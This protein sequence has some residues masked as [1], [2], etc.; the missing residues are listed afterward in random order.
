LRLHWVLVL[1]ITNVVSNHPVFDLQGRH[2]GTPDLLD[3]DTG[4]IGEYDGFL[5]LE[6]RQR[7]RDITRESAFRALGLE[8]VTMVAADRGDLDAYSRRVLQARAR[9][10]A[11]RQSPRRWTVEPP[12]WWTPTVTVEQRRHLT[13]IQRE[14]YLGR[15]V[16]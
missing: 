7:S 2:V 4:L 8:P 5:H 12:P 3:L 14:R 6:G 13:R 9:L 16:G 11:R 1:D 10:W 15:Q